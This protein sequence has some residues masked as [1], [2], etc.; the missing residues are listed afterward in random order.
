MTSGIT[1]ET[2]ASKPYS[3]TLFNVRLH[4]IYKNIICSWV[5]CINVFIRDKEIKL[6]ILLSNNC[7]LA[8][9][10][11]CIMGVSAMCWLISWSQ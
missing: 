3:H 10:W 7:F 1:Q 5:R 11:L 8:N 2:V 6:P 4:C 9:W